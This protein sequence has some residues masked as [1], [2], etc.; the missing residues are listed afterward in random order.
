LNNGAACLTALSGLRRE[1][2]RDYPTETEARRH[3]EEAIAQDLHALK[4]QPCVIQ[5]VSASPPR[6]N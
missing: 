2:I 1:Q 3:V 6:A 4:T 5:A